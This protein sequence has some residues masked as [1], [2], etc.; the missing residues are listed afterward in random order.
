MGWWQQLPYFTLYIFLF[1]PPSVPRHSKGLHLT[2]TSSFALAYP[3]LAE[4][5]LL[6]LHL[7]QF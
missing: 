3:F 1:L 7:H 5:W 6:Q 4:V 2:I